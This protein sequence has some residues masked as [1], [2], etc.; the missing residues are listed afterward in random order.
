ME[1]YILPEQFS[2][3]ETRLVSPGIIQKFPLQLFHSSKLW[4][5]H[6]DCYFAK[7]AIAKLSTGT[8]TETNH[9]MENVSRY[10]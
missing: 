1:Y 2:K 5:N 4:L 9:N 8:Y 10:S 7:E 3:K 6:I